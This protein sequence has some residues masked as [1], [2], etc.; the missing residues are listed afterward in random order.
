M[1]PEGEY[2]TPFSVSDE[3]AAIAEQIRA[4]L[5]GEKTVA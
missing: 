2:A 4:Y 1:N 5:A 3:P